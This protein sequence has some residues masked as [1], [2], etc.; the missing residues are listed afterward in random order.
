MEDRLAEKEAAERKRMLDRMN[1]VREAREGMTTPED[2]AEMAEK[3]SALTEE[4]TEEAGSRSLESLA[5]E[6]P[7]ATARVLT[8]ETLMSDEELE[9]RRRRWTTE[10]ESREIDTSGDATGLARYLDKAESGL[11]ARNEAKEALDR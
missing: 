3:F 4:A 9:A 8:T 11:R 2:L 10:T 6:F 1:R 5:E 7:D